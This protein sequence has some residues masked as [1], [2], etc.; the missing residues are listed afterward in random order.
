MSSGQSV[1]ED[2]SAVSRWDRRLFAFENGL[3]LAAGLLILAVML[4]SVA[5]ILGRKL[6]DLPVPGFVDWMVQAVPLIAF[7]GLAGCQRVGGHIRMDILV[8]QLRGRALW[9]F[10]LVSVVLMLALVVVLAWGAWLH[11]GRSFDWAAPMFSRDST[12][13]I[14]LPTWP[15]KIA[16]PLMLGL[17]AI[18]LVLQAWAYS[19]ALVSG[20]ERPVAV[21]MIESA[22]EQAQNEART[23]AGAADEADAAAQETR[24]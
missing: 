7:L 18:R 5:N 14:N 23:V 20:D 24:P 19:R 6:F 4:L 1:H 9:L 10:E 21:P 2:D 22:A 15:V 17:L 3:T 11:F 13:D 16:V 8:G 12:I